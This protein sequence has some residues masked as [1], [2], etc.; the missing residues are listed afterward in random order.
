MSSSVPSSWGAETVFP[1]QASPAEPSQLQQAVAPKVLTVRRQQQ[2]KQQQQQQQ[3]RQNRQNCSS[4][5]PVDQ[6]QPRRNNRRHQ[7]RQGAPVRHDQAAPCKQ[8]QAVAVPRMY[9]AAPLPAEQQMFSF[10]NFGP[11]DFV[12]TSSQGFRNDVLADSSCFHDV[13]Q[14]QEQKQR[15]SQRGRGRGRRGQSGNQGREFRSEHA[16]TPA[17]NS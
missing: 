1:M 10:G 17:T 3:A 2:P 9:D 12:S 11:S 15:P 5:F 6:Q 8:E 4:N 16:A 14:A 7:R 13:D